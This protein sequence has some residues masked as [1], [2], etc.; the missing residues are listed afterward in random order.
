MTM[1]TA[2]AVCYAAELSSAMVDAVATGAHVSRGAREGEVGFTVRR[3][4]GPW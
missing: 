4:K 2:T 3:K 1:P